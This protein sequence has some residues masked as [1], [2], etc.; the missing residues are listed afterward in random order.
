MLLKDRVAIIT[1][2]GRG[3][4]RATALRF[5]KEGALVVV[6]DIELDMAIAVSK[7]IDA[8]TGQVDLRIT[9]VLIRN[10]FYCAVSFS[11]FL[12]GAQIISRQSYAKPQ[13]ECQA[14]IFN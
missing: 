7:E 3:I 2:G 6:A 10:E 12:H 4:G 9:A 11:H 5:A 1:G 13:R 14:E 8:N